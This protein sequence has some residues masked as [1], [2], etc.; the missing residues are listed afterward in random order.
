MMHR[1]GN[2]PQLRNQGYQSS[3]IL[4]TCIRLLVVWRFNKRGPAHKTETLSCFQLS[5]K[6]VN[7][8]VLPLIRE[9][10]VSSVLR[11]KVKQ[12]REQVMMKN[13]YTRL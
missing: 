12:N 11:L 4:K 6:V 5:R 7:L 3:R 8:P 13:K 1:S 10:S 2:F 9:L